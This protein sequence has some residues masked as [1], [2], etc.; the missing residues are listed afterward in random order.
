[1][2]VGIFMAVTSVLVITCAPIHTQGYHV[3]GSPGLVPG[4]M[5]VIRGGLFPQSLRSRFHCFLFFVFSEGW[6]LLGDEG[7]RALPARPLAPCRAQT[8]NIVIAPVA[9]PSRLA[10]STLVPD[11]AP[12]KARLISARVAGSPASSRTAGSAFAAL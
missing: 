10:T 8:R 11:G 6:Q 2:K 12:R 4:M 5:A 3:S 9:D 7:G 1:M